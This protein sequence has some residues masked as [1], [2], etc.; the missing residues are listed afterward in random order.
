VSKYLKGDIMNLPQELR[1]GVDVAIKKLR[2]SASFEL[3]GT[4]FTKWEDPIS[5]TT[6]PS[7]SEVML[8]LEADR[9]LAEEWENNNNNN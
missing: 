5:G 2:P 9:K 6:A 8:Q 4:N 3:A 7:W 1:W